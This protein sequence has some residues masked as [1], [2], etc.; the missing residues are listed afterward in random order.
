MESYPSNSQNERLKREAKPKPENTEAKG[1]KI[2]ES[3]VTGK[4]VIKKKTLGRRFLDTFIAGDGH[5]V[6]HYVLF[7]VIVPATKDVI[8]DVVSQGVERMVYGEARSTSRR[9]SRPSGT[10]GYVSYNRYSQQN[11]EPSTRP[12][13]SRSVRSSSNFDQVILE[14]RGEALEVIDRLED[15]I[16]R[17]GEATVA[18]LYGLLDKTSQFTDEK[19][20][21]TDI[22]RHDIRRVQQGYQLILPRPVALD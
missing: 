8:A 22:S 10:G 12:G 6:W 7:E 18:D 17:Y 11:R 19:W 21:W 14:T 20:G 16:E 4:V 3:V 15:L 2:V 1:E 13:V 5:G 9:G